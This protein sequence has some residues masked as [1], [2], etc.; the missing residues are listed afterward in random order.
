MSE[1]RTEW[2]V[3]WSANGKDFIESIWDDRAMAEQ[4]RDR[5]SRMAARIE[6]RQVL[7]SPWE[8][9]PNE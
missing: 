3:V 6:S 9:V 8:E 4:V 7:T 1:T 2:R 5:P